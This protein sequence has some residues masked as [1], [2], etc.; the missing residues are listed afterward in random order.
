MLGFFRVLLCVAAIHAQL[1]I[2][3]PYHAIHNYD[4]DIFPCQPSCVPRKQDSLPID[5]ENNCA[6]IPTRNSHALVRYSLETFREQE[7]YENELK[8]SLSMCVVS[9]HSPYS[10]CVTQ[11][12][13]NGD[14]NL[15][16]FK[17]N[18]TNILRP[19]GTVSIPLE[20]TFTWVR[21]IESTDGSVFVVIVFKAEGVELVKIEPNQ[22]W[23]GGVPKYS[24]VV[25]YHRDNYDI[26]G[27]FIVY[28]FWLKTSDSLHVGVRD[29]VSAY[30]FTLDG[31]LLLS[32]IKLT[33]MFI[34]TISY[35]LDS[36]FMGLNRMTL[37]ASDILDH[38]TLLMKI[39]ND[40]NLLISLVDV[41]GHDSYDINHVMNCNGEIV[42]LRQSVFSETS[43]GTIYWIG[44]TQDYDII[45]AKF[46]I[47]NKQVNMLQCAVRN[48]NIYSLLDCVY[49]INVKTESGYMICG[50]G[51]TGE[52]QSAELKFNSN[53]TKSENNVGLVKRSHIASTYHVSLNTSPYVIFITVQGAIMYGKLIE[54]E[55]PLIIGGFR[56]H[57]SFSN[58]TLWTTAIDQNTS[59]LYLCK[60]FCFFCN[61]QVGE[62]T[63]HHGCIYSVDLNAMTYDSNRMLFIPEGNYTRQ[64]MQWMTFL[65]YEQHD[66][67]YFLT[68]NG[69]V[70]CTKTN[71]TRYH[72]TQLHRQIIFKC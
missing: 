36:Q 9:H 69:N 20:R 22:V 43:S 49:G 33:G 61:K 19:I 28:T 6:F 59:T 60:N 27:T 63:Y 7:W 44:I 26:F 58:Y 66:L 4:G 39:S 64:N 14:T 57:Y 48:P 51:D 13:I 71:H 34:L 50:Y 67:L 45:Y 11:K 52:S 30:L 1:T 18:T 24:Q 3:N 46:T 31:E 56:P 40:N 25:V 55:R 72:Q 42:M 16:V 17:F 32:Q 15:I 62:C 41:T 2:Y 53:D 47:S 21:T 37:P 68:T 35:I 10:Y 65:K 23:D 12:T 5:F 38:M 54:N 29:D 8:E 70:L